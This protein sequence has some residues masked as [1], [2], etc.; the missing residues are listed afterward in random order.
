VTLYVPDD[1]LAKL[2]RQ[3]KRAGKSLSAHVV[4]LIENRRPAGWP[5]GF[6][7]LFGSWQGEFPTPEDPPPDEI[8]AL[9]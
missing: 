2:R 9:R 7:D 8:A 6:V 4:A 1:L 3:A 5:S